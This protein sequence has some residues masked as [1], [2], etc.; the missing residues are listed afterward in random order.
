MPLLITRVCATLVPKHSPAI[1]RA[2]YAY[3]ARSGPTLATSDSRYKTGHEARIKLLGGR[4]FPA[5]Q[6]SVKPS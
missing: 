3:D 1:S 4:F 6:L 5:E 2:D